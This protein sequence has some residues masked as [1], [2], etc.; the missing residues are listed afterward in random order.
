MN[1]KKNL[2]LAPFILLMLSACNTP[3]DDRHNAT[4]P[5]VTVQHEGDTLPEMRPEDRPEPDFVT[6][7]AYEEEFALIVLAQGEN[8]QEMRYDRDTLRVP[9][10]RKIMLTLR[11]EATDSFMQHNIVIVRR[12][13]IEEV[14]IEGAR[15][16]GTSYVPQ[17][18]RNVVAFSEVI[19]PGESTTLA[20]NAPKP[21]TYEFVC[22]YPGHWQAMQGIFIVEE[23]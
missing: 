20:F 3:P 22:T 1:L 8:M 5:Q 15:A 16:A 23:Q 14:S 18:S 19:G 2:M 7:E 21:G 10:K 12:G 17:N 11:N 6:G 9:A 13:S 4:D